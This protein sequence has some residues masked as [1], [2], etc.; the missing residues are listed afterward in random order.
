ML[1]VPSFKIFIEYSIS[2]P[3]VTV[4]VL[5]AGNPFIVTK[6]ITPSGSGIYASTAIAAIKIT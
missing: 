5:V 2:C 1:S 3:G 4:V 6:D